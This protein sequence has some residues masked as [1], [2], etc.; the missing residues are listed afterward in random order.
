MNN[1]IYLYNGTFLNLISVIEYL[2]SNK[3][4][5]IN[6]KSEYN[7]EEN[8]FDKTFKLDLKDSEIFIEKIVRDASS[9]VLKL[10]FY[11]FLSNEKNKELIIYYFLLNAFKY[12]GK[13]IYL[14]K[15]KCVN[16]TLRIS[17][18]VSR[19]NHKLK[20]FLR[21]KE[22]ENGFLYAEV[23]P[24]NNIIFL[25]AKHFSLRLKTE[26][27]IIKDV[28]RNILCVYNKKEYI[29]MDGNSLNINLSFSKEEEK[30]QSLWK[31]F[32]KTISI[33]MRENKRCRMNFMPKKYWKYIIE[34]DGEV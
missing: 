28:R 2:I 11:V 15:L 23:E 32:Y 30:Y 6:I 19:E 7:Y 31:N 29:F 12:K 10:I 14:R 34:M 9:Y 5:P 24:T 1:F 26:N 25:L 27:F 33:E 3:I 8:L 17:K 13:V 22:M 20:G 16:E 21:F 18:Y 4:K